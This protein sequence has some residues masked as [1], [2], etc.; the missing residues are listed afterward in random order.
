[1][2]IFFLL[3]CYQNALPFIG[4][5]FLDNVIMISVVSSNRVVQ[6]CYFKK[7]IIMP[8]VYWNM[9]LLFKCFLSIKCLQNYWCT[10]TTPLYMH[11]LRIR[12]SELCLASSPGS[13]SF[14][15]LH[16]ACNIEKLREPGDEAKLCLHYEELAGSPVFSHAMLKRSESLGMRLMESIFFLL[17]RVSTL[18]QPLVWPLGSPL[19][20]LLVLETW[21]LI[22]LDWD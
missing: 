18:T 1:M 7:S 5:G 12:G 8:Q 14:S 15:M 21:Y 19:W 9:I 17:F 3:V 16:A 6:H 13:L 22:W 20:Q 11:S 2:I 10:H 4:F